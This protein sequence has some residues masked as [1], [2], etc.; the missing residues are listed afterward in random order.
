[1]EA[2]HWLN[3]EVLHNFILQSNKTFTPE[4]RESC[5]PVIRRLC[6]IANLYRSYGLE[7][8]GKVAAEEQHVFFKWGLQLFHEC[9]PNGM[10]EKNLMNLISVGG[11]SGKDLLERII[12]LEGIH[13][14]RDGHNPLMMVRLLLTWLGEGYLSRIGE[15]YVKNENVG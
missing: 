7:V 10:I 9:Y 2:M 12:M 4:D 3:V 6:E 8:L 13:M 1:M 11:H 5:L 14:I 15:V